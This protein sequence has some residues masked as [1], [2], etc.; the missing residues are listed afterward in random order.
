MLI[1]LLIA[2]GIVVTAIVV[3]SLLRNRRT[4]SPTIGRNEAP[5]FVSRS[6]FAHPEAPL[7]VLL[8]SSASCDSC[9]QVWDQLQKLEGIAI[10]R[11]DYPERND[12]HERYGITAVPLVLVVDSAGL[13]QSHHFGKCSAEQL[14]RLISLYHW[15]E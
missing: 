4:Q 14:K 7:L 15:V 10:E 6:D 9:V 11:V 8:F 13:V 12:L 2:G 5:S 3:A 1:R